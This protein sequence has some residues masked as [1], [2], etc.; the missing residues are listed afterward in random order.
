VFNLA[1]EHNID[2]VI[3]GERVG[4][5]VSSNGRLDPRNAHPATDP[6]A[7]GRVAEEAA[8]IE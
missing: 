5:I 6:A 8:G 7:P 1:D 4:T 2:R 3:S